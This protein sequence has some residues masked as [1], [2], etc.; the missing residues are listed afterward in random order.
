MHPI[1]QEF[2]RFDVDLGGFSCIDGFGRSGIP[3]SIK[4][5]KLLVRIVNFEQVFHGALRSVQMGDS[6]WVLSRAGTRQVEI[7]VFLKVGFADSDTRLFDLR[8]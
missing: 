4:A 3:R 2:L 1:R 5:R 6:E 7:L 8:I